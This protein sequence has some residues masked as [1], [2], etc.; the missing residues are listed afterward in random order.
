MLTPRVL[1]HLVSP[2]VADA[3]KAA[4]PLPPE[5]WPIGAELQR[6]RHAA[7]VNREVL[8]VIGRTTVESIEN[9]ETGATSWPQALCKSESGRRLV[10]ALIILDE[11]AS[12][13]VKV[14][15]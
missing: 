11:A 10:A 9:Y 2:T 14:Q 1:R 4:S 7:G 15:S 13:P 6:L 3:Y 8:A 5:Q 12:E